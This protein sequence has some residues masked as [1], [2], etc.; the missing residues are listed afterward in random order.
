MPKTEASRKIPVGGGKRSMRARRTNGRVR[1]GSCGPRRVERFDDESRSGQRPHHLLHESAL[2]TDARDARHHSSRNPHA[3][4]DPGRARLRRQERRRAMAKVGSARQAMIRK[5]EAHQQR[6]AAR[7]R[8]PSDDAVLEPSSAR[9]NLRATAP[10]RP[11]NPTKRSI[12]A[13]DELAQYSRVRGEWGPRRRVP[14]RRK[15]ARYLRG[16]RRCLLTAG[17]EVSPADF[18]AASEVGRANEA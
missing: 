13:R 1:K 8:R 18:P 14:E 3:E 12:S 17:G 16:R 5:D 15:N 2:P 10:G 6:I 4:W 9:A 7:H 11:R